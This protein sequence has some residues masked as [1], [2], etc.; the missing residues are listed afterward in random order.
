MSISYFVLFFA[1]YIYLISRKRVQC[2]FV[3]INF[4]TLCPRT[5]TQCFSMCARVSICVKVRTFINISDPVCLY[6]S[7]VLDI[8][9]MAFSQE[10]SRIAVAMHFS[11]HTHIHCINKKFV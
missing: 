11:Y 4:A 9:D 7:F 6:A 8:V 1:R 3:S 2:K 10:S 5:Q